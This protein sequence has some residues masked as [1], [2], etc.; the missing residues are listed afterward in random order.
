MRYFSIILQNFTG[1]TSSYILN[2]SHHINLLSSLT[3]CPK[4]LLVSFNLTSLFTKSLHQIQSLLL[5]ISLPKMVNFTGTSMDSS[6]SPDVDYILMEPFEAVAQES[7][8]YKPK[9]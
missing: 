3:V 1:N 8:F 2:S 9:Y 4:D 6:L 5:V 7:S